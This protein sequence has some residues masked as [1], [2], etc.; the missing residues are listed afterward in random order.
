MFSVVGV[1][2]IVVVDV[3]VNVPSAAFCFSFLLPLICVVGCC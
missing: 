3:A 1:F 2:V